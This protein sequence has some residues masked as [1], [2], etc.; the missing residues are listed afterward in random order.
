[1][2]EVRRNMELLARLTGR[3]DQPQAGVT[4]VILMPGPSDRREDSEDLLVGPPGVVDIEFA[5]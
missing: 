1:M 2:R 3:F 5:R 4:A